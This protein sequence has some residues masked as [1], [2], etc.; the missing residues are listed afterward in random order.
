LAILQG[1]FREITDRL[2]AKK[3]DSEEADIVQGQFQLNSLRKEQTDR[4]SLAWLTAPHQW[5]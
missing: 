3:I 4:H 2:R 5:A 1:N